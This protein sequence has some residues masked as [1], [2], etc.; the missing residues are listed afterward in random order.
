MIDY[1]AEEQHAWI[2]PEL[3]RHRIDVNV[4]PH[5]VQE[6]G[7]NALAELYASNSP[8]VVV[9]AGV[10]GNGT[11]QRQWSKYGS[12]EETIEESVKE[13]ERISKGNARVIIY[14]GRPDL[15]EC[16][17]EH[18]ADGFL[19]KP[20]DPWEAAFVTA[21]SNYRVYWELSDMLYIMKRKA[22]TDANYRNGV[23]I[24]GEEMV[25]AADSEDGTHK[26]FLN[27][28]NPRLESRST[29]VV[30]NGSDADFDAYDGFATAIADA[31]KPLQGSVRNTL[32][33]THMPS[34][35]YKILANA[36][37]KT[38]QR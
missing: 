15:K 37:T 2:S 16:S 34:A 31:R 9:L 3:K 25:G 21:T 30:K 29:A 27:R 12:P 32:G 18:S 7:L 20:F 38:V 24:L 8:D 19:A 10:I 1:R 23:V 35:F 6:H 36:M 33:E 26:E 17:R 4:V 28:L 11:G 5:P 14:T 13:I 22:D